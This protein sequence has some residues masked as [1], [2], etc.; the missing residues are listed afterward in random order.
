MWPI[1]SINLASGSGS[2]AVVAEG[3]W[4]A[5][6]DALRLTPESDLGRLAAKEADAVVAVEMGRE[7]EGA[8][9]SVEIGRVEGPVDTAG[10]DVFVRAWPLGDVGVADAAEFRM[11]YTYG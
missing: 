4:P 8:E 9:K 5:A 11:R 2:T 6:E 7:G 3:E 1:I 10:E